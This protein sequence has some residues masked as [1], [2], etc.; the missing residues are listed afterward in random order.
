MLR[1]VI[2]QELSVSHALS[3]SKWKPGIQYS[4]EFFINPVQIGFYPEYSPSLHNQF[5]TGTG[6]GVS[7]CI[8]KTKHCVCHL[9]GL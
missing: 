3:K 5:R 6:L 2:I 7:D 9:L 8:I 4:P 1:I